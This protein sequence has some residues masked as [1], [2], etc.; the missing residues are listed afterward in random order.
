MVLGFFH[1][2]R[3]QQSHVRL[4]QHN[5]ALVTVAEVPYYYNIM[6]ENSVSGG[7]WG[8]RE[9]VGGVNPYTHKTI[10]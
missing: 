3:F 2:S 7:E 10:S 4:K 1:H 9:G 6:E 5:V 8:R